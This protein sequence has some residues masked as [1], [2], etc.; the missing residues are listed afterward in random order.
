MYKVSAV[1]HDMLA[2]QKLCNLNLNK[3]WYTKLCI[4]APFHCRLTYI[5]L[6]AMKTWTII[7]GFLDSVDNGIIVLFLVFAEFDPMRVLIV[8]QFR[9]VVDNGII[10][11]TMI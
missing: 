6:I 8:M 1:T 7:C 2:E 5:W 11:F 9:N 3:K 4:T 10:K